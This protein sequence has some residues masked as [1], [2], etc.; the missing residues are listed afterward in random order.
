MIPGLPQ[1]LDHELGR[2]AAERHV[3]KS[4]LVI[5][6]VRLLIE[7]AHSEALIERGFQLALSHEGEA[8]DWL[9]DA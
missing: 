4:A 8:L 1:D 7:K 9:T 5:E 6:G 3:S 2:L